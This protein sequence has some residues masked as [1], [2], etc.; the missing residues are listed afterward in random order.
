MNICTD[1]T[2]SPVKMFNLLDDVGWWCHENQGHTVRNTQEYNA[3]T[4]T[5][6][7]SLQARGKTKVTTIKNH[8]TCIKT[9]KKRVTDHIAAKKAEINKS[10]QESLKKLNERK[11]A[12]DTQLNAQEVRLCNRL[13]EMQDVDER[14]IT[15]NWE[16]E[17]VSG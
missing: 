11:A 10:Y 7:E 13:D 2:M 8:V 15:S 6:I 12:L 9:Q 16:C 14:L 17:C 4:K 5:K 1:V 3:S